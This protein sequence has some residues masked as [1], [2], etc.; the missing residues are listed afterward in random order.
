M[1]PYS[2]DSSDS[3]SLEWPGPFVEEID[4]REIE[5]FEVVGKGTFGLVRKG[6]WRDQDVAV[7]SIASDHEKRAFLVE[8]R[9][10]SRVDHP[11]IVKLYGARVR[12]PVCLVM[13]YAEG[14]S[15]YN[16]LHTM[17]QVPY[18]LAH[19][20]SWMLQCARGVAY[21]HSMKPKALVHR[22]LKP[23]N[24]LLVNG[25]T[26]LKICDFGTACDVQTQMTNNKGSA[27]WM[28]PE[29]FESSTY[30]EKCDIFSWGIILW[31]VLTRR[32]PFEDCGPPAFCI[33][34]A[35]HQGKRPPLIRGCPTVLEELM[36]NCWSKHA[37]QRPPM[38]EVEKTMDHLAAFVPGADIPLT[39]PAPQRN[40]AES[41][42]NDEWSEPAGLGTDPSWGSQRQATSLVV[43]G[44]TNTTT[45]ARRSGIEQPPQ[46][47][48]PP[49]LSCSIEDLQRVA[50]LSLQDGAAGDASA[51]GAGVVP[52][53]TP[54]HRRVGSAGS[55]QPSMAAALDAGDHHTPQL[56]PQWPA[57]TGGHPRPHPS[58]QTPLL[59]R[60][61]P[62]RKTSWPATPD[63]PQ[64]VDLGLNA[65][66]LIEPA[67]Q[68]LS[69]VPS[70]QESVRIFDDHRCLAQWYFKL[71]SEICLLNQRSKELDKELE[72]PVSEPR[73]TYY[74]EAE[75]LEKEQ[76][77]LKLLRES[78]KNQ[79]QLLK[80]QQRQD[81]RGSQPG[82]Q[83]GSGNE[84][85][86]M[87]PMPR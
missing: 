2:G 22:D 24:L 15:L 72:V 57:R 16:V 65:H 50:E 40:D 53:W 28:A 41:P 86:V 60:P 64:E 48:A 18:T 61:D 1:D 79:L 39:Y 81:Q 27:A 19:A 82:S 47:S 87:V 67:L 26:V 44:A 76:E 34:W 83:P 10:L 54:G 43:H 73:R 85:W 29:V 8:V 49:S 75:Q 52:S 68:P 70:C 31:E 36:V 69:P 20:L 33:M 5:L 12:T 56:P 35:V 46:M 66:L 51:A 58:F 74:D 30:S 13:E 32:K 4:H 62:S 14:G 37:E 6:R 63:C 77:Q 23:P 84:E 21:L 7:K 3:G 17:K 78:L 11:N 59:L 80:Q 9:Q 45:K 55:Q 42:G 25:G 71:Q 38:A